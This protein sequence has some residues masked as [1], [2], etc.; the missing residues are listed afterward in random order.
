M[1]WELRIFLVALV[2]GAG[3]GGEP[4]RADVA[5]AH[6]RAAGAEVNEIAA[7]E[8]GNRLALGDV[9][10]VADL[11]FRC[12]APRANAPSLPSCASFNA[13]SRVTV[14]FSKTWLA[15]MMAFISA[16]M[17]GNPR[18]RCGGRVRRHS[19]SRFRRRGRRRTGRRARVWR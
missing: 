10:E 19:K 6:Q 18:A 11:E 7:L 17:A 9:R 2:V 4:E 16:S 8:I 1:R 14:I 5:G 3:H 15:L 13:C 12:L